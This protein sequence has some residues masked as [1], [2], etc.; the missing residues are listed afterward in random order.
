MPQVSIAAVNEDIKS[1][2]DQRDTLVEQKIKL[3][4]LSSVIAQIATLA[5]LLGPM[6]FYLGG[7]YQNA[8]RSI[9]LLNSQT[10]YTSSMALRIQG[11]EDR[12]REVRA[13]AKTKGFVPFTIDVPIVPIK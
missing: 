11:I 2:I 13:W 12:Q 6:I 5:V 4:I 9:E 7:I 1:Y 8:N 3:W 10:Q